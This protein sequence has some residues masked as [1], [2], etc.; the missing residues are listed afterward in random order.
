MQIIIIFPF[1]HPRAQYNQSLVFQSAKPCFIRSNNR[2]LPLHILHYFRRQ[3]PLIRQAHLGRESAMGNPFAGGPSCSFFQHAVDLF[4]GE[5]LGFG[6]EHVGVDEAAD[7]EGAPDEED[8]GAEVAL[9]G[10]DHVGGYD[11]NNL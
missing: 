8:F 3:G 1:P 5:A 9:V 2:S 6:D 7:A 4:E 11:G 10:V